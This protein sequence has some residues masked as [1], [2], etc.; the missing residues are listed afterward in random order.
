MLFETP[1]TRVLGI[2]P[3]CVVTNPLTLALRHL[4]GAPGRW[5]AP[6]ERA[7]SPNRGQC[8][9]GPRGS[10][11]EGNDVKV[12]RMAGRSWEATGRSPQGPPKAPG[13][14]VRLRQRRGPNGGGGDAEPGGREARRVCRCAWVTA[15]GFLREVTVLS[16]GLSLLGTEFPSCH[17]F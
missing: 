5:D 11:V 16:P 10:P 1:Q 15:P 3:S 13:A 4:P 12:L 14:R 2:Q 9:L 8:T 7:P 17:I 6:R